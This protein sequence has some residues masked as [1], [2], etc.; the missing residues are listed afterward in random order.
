MAVQL[1]GPPGLDGNPAEI[2]TSLRDQYGPYRAWI[3]ATYKADQASA[4]GDMKAA[5]HWRRVVTALNR[6]E[7]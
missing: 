5:L 4:S 6:L 1:S 7:A 2:A 3:F